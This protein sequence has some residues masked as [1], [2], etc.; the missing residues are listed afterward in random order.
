[1]DHY[2]FYMCIVVLARTDCKTRP[3]PKCY[4]SSIKDQ[5]INQPIN[6]LISLYQRA[7]CNNR[8]FSDSLSL[9]LSLTDTHTHTLSLS[10]SLSHIDTN[11]NT[12]IH[13]P[14]H[15]HTNTCKR[16]CTYART[17]SPSLQCLCAKPQAKPTINI[18]LNAVR[19]SA[20][21]YLL[22]KSVADFQPLCVVS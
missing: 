1:M 11:A 20:A 14:T 13:T 19:P 18:V 9:S 5:S 3:L 12:H 6:Q 17:L 21:F 2:S 15:A 8:F 4:S 7:D 10:L 22:N 16:T